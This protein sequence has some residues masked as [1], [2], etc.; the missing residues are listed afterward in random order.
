MPTGTPSSDRTIFVSTTSSQTSWQHTSSTPPHPYSDHN[1]LGLSAKSF[2][3]TVICS[4]NAKQMLLKH[5]VYK[6][7]ALH[8]MEYRSQKTRTFSH[9]KVDPMKKILS[10]QGISDCD[11]K[12]FLRDGFYQVVATFGRLLQPN[13]NPLRMAILPVHWSE[14]KVFN[15]TPRGTITC[16]FY[17]ECGIPFVTWKR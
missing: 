16:T 6:E 9:L 12:Q 2:G 11:L 10:F 8:E 15:E 1:I 7:R 4:K 13:W 3:Y 14:V 17:A 5:E